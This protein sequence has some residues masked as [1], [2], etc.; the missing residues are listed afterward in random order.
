MMEIVQA[1]KGFT[2]TT[3]SD[4]GLFPD[5]YRTI[6]KQWKVSNRDFV[7]TNPNPVITSSAESYLQFNICKSPSRF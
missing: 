5:I 3:F 6:I 2:V 1:Q 4:Q 7:N